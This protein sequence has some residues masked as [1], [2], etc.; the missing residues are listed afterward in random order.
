[1]FSHL[2]R[3]HLLAYFSLMTLDGGTFY[4]TNAAINLLACSNASNMDDE[5]FEIKLY[6]IF[7]YRCSKLKGME[8]KYGT[9]E[10]EGEMTRNG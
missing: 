5:N 6:L 4:F 3:A 1:M 10:R 9:R 7:F 2:M 8:N